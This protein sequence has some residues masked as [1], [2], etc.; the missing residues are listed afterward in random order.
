MGHA[1]RQA[2]HDPWAG[3]IRPSGRAD[4]GCG[5]AYWARAQGCKHRACVGSSK[6]RSVAEV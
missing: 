6:D 5:R 3:P 4:V 2:S 1:L